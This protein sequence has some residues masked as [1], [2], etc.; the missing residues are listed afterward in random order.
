MSGLLDR[1]RLV[2]NQKGKLIEIK[3]EFRIMDEDGA[4]IGS[5]RQENQSALK[6]VL[7]FVSSVDQFL[8]H[9]LAVYDGDD[10]KVCEVTRPAKIFKSRV[11]VKDGAGNDV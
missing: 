1:D 2:I 7:R 4:Q 9:T 6:K 5:I 10:S 8:T 11:L 3:T